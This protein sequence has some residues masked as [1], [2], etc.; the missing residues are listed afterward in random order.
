MTISGLHTQCLRTKK[1]KLSMHVAYAKCARGNV[2]RNCRGVRS[3]PGQYSIRSTHGTINPTRECDRSRRICHYTKS[4]QQSADISHDRIV[5]E[6]PP[7]GGQTGEQAAA[8]SAYFLDHKIIHH[9]QID[10]SHFDNSVPSD[11]SNLAGDRAEVGGYAGEIFTTVN[12]WMSI[13]SRSVSMTT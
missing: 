1:V 11:I 13:M 5:E 9:G 2:I 10:I 3:A 12:T 8:L 6:S 7:A 4:K